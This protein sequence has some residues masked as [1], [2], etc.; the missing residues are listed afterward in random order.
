MLGEGWGRLEGGDGR[1][2]RKEKMRQRGG[3]K[4]HHEWNFLLRPVQA[5]GADLQLIYGCIHCHSFAGRAPPTSATGA[6]RRAG[7]G[8]AAG[9]RSQA[10]EKRAVGGGCGGPMVRGVS[11]MAGGQRGGILSKIPRIWRR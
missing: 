10:V 5:A 2:E 1:G 11:R 4:N 7:A 9:S 3:E 8:R 6:A